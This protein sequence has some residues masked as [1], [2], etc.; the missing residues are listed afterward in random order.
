MIL[1]SQGFDIDLDK[2][3]T[4]S[5]KSQHRSQIIKTSTA[6]SPLQTRHR[7]N[8]HDPAKSRRPIAGSSRSNISMPLEDPYDRPGKV[9]YR[10]MPE[11]TDLPVD[12]YRR[13]RRKKPRT[14]HKGALNDPDVIDLTYLDGSP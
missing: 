9:H 3:K 6:R 8:G 7:K 13:S 14:G 4:K 10:N 2:T 5:S 11:D 12:P 1:A